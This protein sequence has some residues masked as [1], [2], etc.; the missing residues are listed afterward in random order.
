MNPYIVLLLSVL[1]EVVALTALRYVVGVTKPLPIIIVVVA[2]ALS[3]YGLYIVLK[4]LP[5]GITYAIWAGLGTVGTI[6]VG[7]VMFKEKPDL[8]AWVGMLLIVGGVMVINL[9]SKSSTA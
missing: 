8:M 2:Y 1:G 3:F 7:M 4:T 9:L 5:V 6:V